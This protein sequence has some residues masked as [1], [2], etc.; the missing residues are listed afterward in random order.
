MYYLYEFSKTAKYIGVVSLVVTFFSDLM[1]FK[2]LC[3]FGLFAFIEIA[4]NFSV[5]KCSVLQIIGIFKVK[6]KF[7]NEVP[8]VF[9]YKSEIE[10]TLPFEG[11]WVVVN[12]CYTKEFS[13][14]WDIPTQRYAYDFIILDE[15]GKSYRNEFNQCESYYCYDKNILAPADGIV[16]EIL[17]VAKDSLIF[18]KGKFFSKSPHIAG[19]YIVIKHS[20]KEYSTFAHLKKD[21]ITVKVGDSIS[22][23]DIIAKCGNTGNSTEPH[24]HFQLQTGQ[25]FYNSA[26]LPIKFNNIKLTIAPNYKRFDH[27]L[28]MPKEQILEGYISRG[29][30]VSAG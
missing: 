10:Y 15:E 19:N 20:E 24:L 26:G 11:Q 25:S 30:N 4:L 13:H 17:N 9:N 27:R 18:K 3:L 12:G 21:S 6:R 29:Y 5:F 14:S 8:S 23:G 1:I 7:G 16:V 2:L 22:R 28:S